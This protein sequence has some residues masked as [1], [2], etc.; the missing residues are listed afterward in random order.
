[1]TASVCAICHGEGTKLCPAHAAE[2]AS[3]GLT[4]AQ[5]AAKLRDLD[6]T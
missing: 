3:S 4:P 6:L 2:V 1:M 5:V